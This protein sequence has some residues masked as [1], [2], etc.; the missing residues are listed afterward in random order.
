MVLSEGSSLDKIS[1]FERIL[2]EIRD[3]IQESEEFKD[4]PIYFDTSQMNPNVSLPAIS[5]NVGQKEV[6][7]S[8]ALCTNYSRRLGIWLH[9]ETLDKNELLSELYSYE[10]QLVSVLNRAKL[11]SKL[12]DFYE[13]EE[14]GSSSINAL[15]FNARKEANQFNATF[16]SNLL[17]VRFV[18]KYEI[19]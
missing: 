7:S 9:T 14:T 18:I 16:F 8:S 4:I 12:S 3:V 2:V 10:E 1:V 15:M 5:F 11:S 19:E 6:L 17:R 13:I